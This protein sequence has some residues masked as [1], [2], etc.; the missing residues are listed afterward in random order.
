MER[1]MIDMAAIP[2]ADDYT[3]ARIRE[4]LRDRQAQAARGP[5][6]RAVTVDGHAATV[7][8]VGAL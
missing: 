8:Q 6:G 2:A 7:L 3:V 1:Q 5:Q 4:A